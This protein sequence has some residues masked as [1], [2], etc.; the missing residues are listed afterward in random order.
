MLSLRALTRAVPRTL[1]QR[2][3]V[4]CL[5]SVSRTPFYRPVWQPATKISYPAFSTSC[6]RREPAG[7]CKKRSSGFL[8]R[9]ICFPADQE[10]S[11]KIDQEYTLEV[12]NNDNSKLEQLNQYLSESAFEVTDKPGTHE[13]ALT[14]EFGNEQ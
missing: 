4:R 9:L 12:E 8:R 5:S 6:S 13:V 10:L 2:S 11:A 7:E 1:F 14:R 3:T